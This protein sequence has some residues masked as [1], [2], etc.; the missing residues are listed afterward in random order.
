MT[1][2]IGQRG[3]PEIVGG[4]AGERPG[5]QHVGVHRHGRY[6]VVHEIAA[7]PVPVAHHHGHGH[8]CVHGGRG[9]GPTG[10][11]RSAAPRTDGPGTTAMVVMMVRR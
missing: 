6:V 3:A 1:V 11:P 8:G 9:V 10:G 2:R 5:A 4:H 7:Q